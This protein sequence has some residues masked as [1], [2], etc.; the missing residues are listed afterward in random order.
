MSLAGF[1]KRFLIACI[2][3]QAALFSM[4]SQAA[5][6][7]GQKFRD[8]TARCEARKERKEQTCFVFQN[9]LLKKENKRLL[10]VAVGYLVSKEQPVAF[11][12]L[13]LGVSLPGGVSLTVDD[14][15]PIRVRY[16]RCDASGCLAPLAL[17]ET[18]VNSLKGGRWARV[19][20]FDATRREVS[21]PVS[22]LGFTSGMKSL[23]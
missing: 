18:L 22:L 19:A 21:V 6:Q 9:L 8:W 11:F 23:K 1:T 7:T 13:P 4:S 2:A 15:K 5:P 17:T 16:E 12:T 14:G 10:H 3:L 20:F